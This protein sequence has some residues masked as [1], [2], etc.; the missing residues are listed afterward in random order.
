MRLPIDPQADPARRAWV[1]CP[2]CDDASRC[3]SCAG[4][5]NCTDHWRYLISNAGPVVQLQC[6]Q[7]THMWS[8]NTRPQAGPRPGGPSSCP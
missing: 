4:G 5:R 7:C 6:P 3:A 8:L 1:P 2:V